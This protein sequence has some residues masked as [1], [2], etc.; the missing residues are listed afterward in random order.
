L[1]SRMKA[2]DSVLFLHSSITPFRISSQVPSSQKS[3][4][5]HFTTST[6]KKKKSKIIH[7]DMGEEI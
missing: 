3:A 2:I 1:P 4:T 6:V 7:R 5:N